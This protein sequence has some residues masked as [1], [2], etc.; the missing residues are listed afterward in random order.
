MPIIHNNQRRYAISRIKQTTYP[1]ATAANSS[2]PYNFEQLILK[3]TPGQNFAN[4]SVRVQNNQGY[5]TGSDFATEQWLTAH[6]VDRQG[7]DFDVSSETIGR[8]LYYALGSVE[9]TSPATGVYN[10]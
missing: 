7:M 2:A 3:D 10:H 1:T 5:S 6:D 9:T 4:Y 8:F